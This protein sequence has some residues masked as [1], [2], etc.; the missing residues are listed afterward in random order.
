[1]IKGCVSRGGERGRSEKY[2][3]PRLI[4][5]HCPRLGEVRKRDKLFPVIFSNVLYTT[6]I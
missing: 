4:H 6:V 1:M 5:S 3:P 2:R